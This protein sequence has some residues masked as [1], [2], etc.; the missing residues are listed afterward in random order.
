MRET[1][2]HQPV[3]EYLE[4]NGYAVYAEVRDAD[5]AARRDD[6]LIVVE[7]KTSAN[8]KLLVQA[9]DRQSAADEVYVA[10]PEP[11]RRNRHVRGVEHVLKRLG[12]G[13]IHVRFSPLGASAFVVFDAVPASR[14]V[15]ARHRDAMLSE[16]A[17]RTI[18]QNIAGSTGKPLLTAYRERA[19][20]I[21]CCLDEMGPMSPR[22]LVQLGAGDKTSAML[23]KNHY[24][25]FE[26]VSRGVY[27][28]A[29]QALEDIQ[30]YADTCAHA[31]RI[32][33]TRRRP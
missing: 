24:G 4:S 17:G 25:W 18:D 8:L 15:I 22:E 33:D 10:L 32:I 12:L 20:Y 16:M 2:L 11:A 29:P 30:Q 28:L 6:Q 5:I 21:A 13:L 3:K 31:R 7:L 1:D 27:R 23:A 14:P 19:I 26:R 9:A